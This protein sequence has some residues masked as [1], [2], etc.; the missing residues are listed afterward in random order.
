MALIECLGC[1]HRISSKAKFCPKCGC[2]NHYEQPDKNW[3][4]AE[5][6]A[7]EK[8]APAEPIQVKQE[9]KAAIQQPEKLQPAATEPQ[10]KPPTI[11]P[12]PIKK[13]EPDDWYFISPTGRNG[14]VK[15]E[16]L[17]QLVE[18]GKIEKEA[19]VWKA[20]LPDWIM[21][22]SLNEIVASPAVEEPIEAEN[23]PVSNLYI[24]TVA[25]APFWGTIVQ[26][27]ATEAWIKITRQSLD[28]Y[29]Q[30]WW[31]LLASNLAV[32]YI[33]SQKIKKSGD[34]RIEAW[35][36]LLV[37]AYIFRR[38]RNTGAG[39]FRF[40][41]WVGSAIFSIASLVAMSS[42]YSRITGK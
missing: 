42:I 40:W 14:P 36:F 13:E 41:I 7:R 38:D 6:P 29:S 3:A 27:I 19:K 25:L 20:G 30:F 5:L 10:T 39:M 18:T 12:Q 31:I 4:K 1:G 22:S 8:I 32:S 21:F 17:Q 33:D 23:S 24:W 16:L 37:P 28:Y 34:T 26:I 2:T 11:Q 15:F 9:V 35:F